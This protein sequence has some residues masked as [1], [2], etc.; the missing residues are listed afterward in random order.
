M[1]RCVYSTK[2]LNNWEFGNDATEKML[3]VS[4]ISVDLL[5]V[6]AYVFTELYYP[7]LLTG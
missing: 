2:K 1:P 5:C 4:A 3:I 6:A 7:V